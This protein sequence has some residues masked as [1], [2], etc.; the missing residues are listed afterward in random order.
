MGIPDVKAL[1]SAV[2]KTLIVADGKV[3]I[4]EWT[5][6]D[7]IVTGLFIE[8]ERRPANVY[9]HGEF[10]DQISVDAG[11]QVDVFADSVL[12]TAHNGI[13][14]LLQILLD[15]R[16][17]R[18]RHVAFQREHFVTRN[19]EGFVLACGIVVVCV[20]VKLNQIS[21]VKLSGVI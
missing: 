12:L 21:R 17:L 2:A 5:E 11:I 6:I 19:N 1:A 20:V 10:F 3:E 9:V 15:I 7:M 16:Y 8:E 13:V 14:N 18:G 4:P